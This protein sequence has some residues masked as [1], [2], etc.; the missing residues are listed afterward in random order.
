MTFEEK[1]RA[2][3]IRE[4]ARYMKHY[5]ANDENMEGPG[6]GEVDFAPIFDALKEIAFEGYVSVEVFKF[7]PG[8][9]TIATRSLEYMKQKLRD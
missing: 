2:E 7:E 4:Y 1:S 9:E 8:P 6:F 3:L 5:H